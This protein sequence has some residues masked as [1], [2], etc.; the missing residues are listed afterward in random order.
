M[1]KTYNVRSSAVRRLKAHIPV[2]ATT[3]VPAI[4]GWPGWSDEVT[5]KPGECLLFVET[6][7]ADG[8]SKAIKVKETP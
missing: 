8:W 7:T 5:L 6:G 2:L 4:K 3:T 1:T